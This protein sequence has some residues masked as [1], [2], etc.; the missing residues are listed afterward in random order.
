MAD[1]FTVTSTTPGQV[2]THSGGTLAARPA[3]PAAGDTY[4][5]TTGAQTGARYTCFVTGSWE[6]TALPTA[7][8][9]GQV[10]VSDGAGSAY[11]ATSA[12]DVL[13][14]GMVAALAG[15]PAGAALISDGAGDIATTSADVSAMLAAADAAAALA[16]LGVTVASPTVYD[17]ASSTG[18]TLTNGTGTASVTGGVARLSHGAGTA[19]RGGTLNY[20]G[21]SITRDLGS[22]YDIGIGYVDVAVRI[23]SMPAVA[24]TQASLELAASSSAGVRRGALAAQNGTVYLYNHETSGVIAATAA[25]ALDFTGGQ[26]WIRVRASLGTVRAYY[27]VGVGGARPT[28]WTQVGTGWALSASLRYVAAAQVVVSTGSTSTLDLDDLTVLASQGD[29][30]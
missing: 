28:T 23:A 16:A 17:F 18:F 14:L 6:G 3:S 30:L 1:R 29:G 11:T 25:G 27:G 12:G 26:G 5:V 10:P 24:T 4:A 9:A 20:N 13:A 7:S 21:P 15:E 22:A 8:A 2:A 19:Y